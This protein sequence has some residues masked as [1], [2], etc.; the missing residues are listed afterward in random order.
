MSISYKATASTTLLPSAAV[1]GVGS[2]R[3][4]YLINEEWSNTSR[5]IL[6]VEKLEVKV[7]AEFGDTVSIE[8]ELGN[9]RIAYMEDRAILEGSEVMVYGQ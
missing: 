8:N 7:L 1:R 2:N 9:S 3:Y 4:V 5:T 6:R